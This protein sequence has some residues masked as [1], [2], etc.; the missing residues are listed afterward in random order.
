MLKSI[1]RLQL[2]RIENRLAIITTAA[3][4]YDD[5]VVDLIA[6]AAPNSKAEDEWSMR[7]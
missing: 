2:S 1:I 3:F 4:T 7:F 5:A 6:S